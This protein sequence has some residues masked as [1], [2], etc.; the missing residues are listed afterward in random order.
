VKT[1][2]LNTFGYENP[3]SSSE[4]SE[5]SE[6][7]SNHAKKMNELEKYLEAIANRSDLQEVG[8]VRP[9]SVEWDVAPYPPR[10]K[11]PTLHTF[12]DKESPNQHIY[13][14]KSQTGNVVSND[15]I[16]TRLFISELPLNGS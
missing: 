12:D 16:M 5:N 13:Y 2:L 7:E 3:E 15:A 9:Y 8:V 10:F 6:A 4:E 14:F 1:L 11:A